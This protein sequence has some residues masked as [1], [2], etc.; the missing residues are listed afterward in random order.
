MLER[1]VAAAQA[2]Q[3]S[4][5]RFLMV[6]QEEPGRMNVAQA[7]L[8]IA[9]GQKLERL[10]MGLPEHLMRVAEMTTDELLAEYR[11]LLSGLAPGSGDTG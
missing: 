4:G 7:R 8:Y 3:A 5:V 10:A 1:H 2:L 9:V 11:Q 6:L